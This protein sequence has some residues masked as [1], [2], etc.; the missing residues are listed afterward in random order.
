MYEKGISAERILPREI[1][2]GVTPL[3]ENTM[4]PLKMAPMA[5]KVLDA[6]K[7]RSPLEEESITMILAI[8]EQAQHNG[9]SIRFV[10]RCMD[11]LEHMQRV[12]KED[13]EA[14]AVEKA[15]GEY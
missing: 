7:N 15:S 8:I 12:A 4:V 9:K 14:E 2:R 11:V 6:V 5:L 1:A 3:L 13:G 10:A